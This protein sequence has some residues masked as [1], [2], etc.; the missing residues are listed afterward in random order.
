M[1]I[2]NI[3]GEFEFMKSNRLA[4]PLLSFGWAVRMDV[5]A[6]WHL[7]VSLPRHHPAGV[8]KLIAVVINS[9]NVH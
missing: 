6:F 2:Q 5:H 8:V 1:L 3:I 4:H 9:D 7:W